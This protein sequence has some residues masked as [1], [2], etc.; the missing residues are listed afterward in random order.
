MP[1]DLSSY[2]RVLQDGWK[3]YEDQYGRPY[4]HNTKT[5]VSTWKP[6]RIVVS[7]DQMI[8]VSLIFCHSKKK[9]DNF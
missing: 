6:P 2:V 3:A 8:I 1:S 4:F 5:G 9:F 7:C